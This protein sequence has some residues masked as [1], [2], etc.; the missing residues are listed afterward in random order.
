[1]N[2]ISPEISVVEIVLEQRG[3]LEGQF[4]VRRAT[5]P[6]RRPTSTEHTSI[7]QS[8]RSFRT[9]TSECECS[10]SRGIRVKIVRGYPMTGS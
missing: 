8:I 5:E 1:V 7:E 2:E 6:R 4:S 3:D 9:S 10:I